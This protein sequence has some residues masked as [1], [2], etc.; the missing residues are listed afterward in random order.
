MASMI[1]KVILFISSFN[2]VTYGLFLSSLNLRTLNN[3]GCYSVGKRTGF[4]FFFSSIFTWNWG[5]ENS[6]GEQQEKTQ[7]I[8]NTSATLQTGNRYAR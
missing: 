3:I 2:S 6:L 5:E 4:A 1:P 8:C 7:K